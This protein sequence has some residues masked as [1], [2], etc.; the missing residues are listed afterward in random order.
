MN[1][2]AP[3]ALLLLL[4]LAACSGRTPGPEG[5]PLP[6]PA[7]TAEMMDAAGKRIGVA[8]FTAG[9][10]GATLAISVA[11]L[12]PGEH[13]IHIHQNGDC[14]P[15]AFTTAGPHFNPGA[16]QHGLETPEGPH[17]GDLPNLRVEA[18]GSA[19]TSLPLAS[20]LLRPGDRSI[21]GVRATALVIHAR[22]DDQRTDP[23]GNSGDRIAC[24]VIRGE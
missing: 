2:A 3:S 19:D 4:G 9:D 12:P 16:R 6:E 10:T 1:H 24:G 11:G 21:L 7:A 18:D 13:G 8:T 23:S 15:P 22:P 14:T 20:E 17:A 5:R